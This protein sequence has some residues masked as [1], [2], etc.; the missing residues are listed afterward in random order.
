MT[1]ERLLL[2]HDRSTRLVHLGAAIAIIALVVS[3]FGLADLMPD[4]V[5]SLFGGHLAFDTMHRLFGLIFS[6]ALVLLPVLMPARAK[7]LVRDVT[8]FHRPDTR[9]PL[10]FLRFFLR[11]EQHRPP[12]HKGRF[13][14]AQRVIFLGLGISLLLLVVSGVSLYLMPPSARML[15]AWAV[16]I[17]IFATVVLI[18]CAGIHILAGSGLLW[19]HRGVT[20]AMFGNGRVRVSLARRLW[21]HWARRTAAESDLA[22]PAPEVDASGRHIV[23]SSPEDPQ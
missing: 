14:P 1:R 16:R 12:H 17:H 11:P 18:V 19:T 2:R 21:P 10:A 22:D 15:L 7:G 20:R 3:G 6:A 9:W 5:V 8:D 4:P 23:N 13:D